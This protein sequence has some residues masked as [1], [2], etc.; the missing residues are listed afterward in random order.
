M[1]FKIKQYI[2]IWNDTEEIYLK[3]TWL[4]DNTYESHNSQC[5]KQLSIYSIYWK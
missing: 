1:F 4:T 3:Y 5:V 2:Q